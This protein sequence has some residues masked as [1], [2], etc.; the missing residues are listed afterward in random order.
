[1]GAS[2]KH[3]PNSRAIAAKSNCGTTTT[4]PTYTTHHSS[5]CIHS[6][7]PPANQQSSVRRCL[8]SLRSRE[9]HCDDSA[10][11]PGA[12]RRAHFAT[13]SY[14]IPTRA[15]TTSNPPTIPV[16]VCS[17]DITP[18]FEHG[19]LGRLSSLRDCTCPH[20]LH[21]R[22]RSTGANTTGRDL[23]STTQEGGEIPDYYRVIR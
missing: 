9:T 17:G 6:R 19:G 13:T 14:A 21:S 4:T 2:S 8:T 18:W 15:R 5:Y 7:Q 22:T 3:S 1:L 20:L 11:H 16:D 10:M 12:M 23:A